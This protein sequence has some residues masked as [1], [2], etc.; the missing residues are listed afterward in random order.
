MSEMD[1]LEQV[2]SGS[3]PC[4]NDGSLLSLS[5]EHSKIWSSRLPRI[6]LVG[7]KSL[8]KSKRLLERLKVFGKALEEQSD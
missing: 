2:T 6:M 3:K 4:H 1:D 7:L 5:V 8:Y